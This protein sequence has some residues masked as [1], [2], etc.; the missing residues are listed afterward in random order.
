M[1]WADTPSAFICVESQENTVGS[2]LR[3]EVLRINQNEADKV[4]TT[5]SD[6]CQSALRIP[7]GTGTASRP[8]SHRSRTS[9]RT[10]V[11]ALCDFGRI[12]RAEK[13]S[14]RESVD[15][16]RGIEPPPRVACFSQM[17]FVSKYPIV[18]HQCYFSYSAHSVENVL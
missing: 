15:S 11:A 17:K 12:G 16:E 13:P 8:S 10:A 6:G 4:L 3:A 14:S 7:T 9:P 18:W 1:T 5:G 2:S